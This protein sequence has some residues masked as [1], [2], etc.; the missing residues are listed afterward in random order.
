[1]VEL[2]HENWI[3]L[4]IALVIGLLT[5]WWVL[6]ASR[7][8]KVDI[9]RSEDGAPAKRNQALI[10]ARPAAAPQV[11]IPPQT[12]VGLAG[13]GE[14]VAAAA[15]PVEVAPEPAPEPIPEPTPEPT[16]APAPTVAPASSG[17]ADD[18]TR[19][20][21]LGPKIALQLK[22][23]GV[24]TFAQIA[25]WDDAEI[26]RIDAQLGRFQGRI[27]RD[28]WP[29]Q[30]RLLAAGDTSGYEAKFGKL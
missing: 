7:R 3:F 13:V 14:A 28:D 21:G 6:V 1:M 24:S 16:P 4:V 22:D 11:E 23:L 25:A 8:T 15:A 9:S 26:D 10:D 30:A 5:A 12:P 27:R 19:I 20:K 17:P 29:T 18:L 2:V